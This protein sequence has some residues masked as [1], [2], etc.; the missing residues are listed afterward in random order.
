M[1][2][3]GRAYYDP[4]GRP[5]RME[6]IAL[7]ITPQKQSERALRESVQRFRN[8]AESM[9][10]LLWQ[11]NA[12]GTL[13]YA[14]QGWMSYFGRTTIALFE[15]GDV[16]HPDDLPRVYGSWQDMTRGEV[17]IDPFRLRRH[18][19]VYRWFGCRSV[20]V[21]DD[22]GALLHI[23]GISTDVDELK[24][25]E[26][27]LRLSQARL[28]AALG[29]AGMGTWVWNIDD[30][31]FT[32]D[33]SMLQL[34]GLEAQPES[35]EQVEALL[36]HPEDRAGLKEAVRRALEQETDFEAEYRI[37]GPDQKI[38]W[39][40]SKGQLQK[41][42]AGGPRRLIGASMDV[43]QHRRLEDELR[44]AQKMEAIGQLAGGVAHD[45]NNLLT[46]ILGQVSLARFTPGIP[47]RTL[48]SIDD[49]A[50]AAE[51]AASLTAQL[52]AFGRRQVMDA[53]DLVLDDMVLGVASM[54]ERMLGEQV[55]MT[56]E[57]SLERP[58]VHADSNML[59][60]VLLNLAINARDAMPGGG[61]LSVRVR[62]VQ[63]DERAAARAPDRTVRDYV[64]LSVSDTGSGIPTEILPH[65]FEPFFTTKELGKGTG[66]GLATA[67][68]IVRQHRGF[69]DVLS[70]PGSGTTFDIFLPRAVEQE[71]VE[72]K[73][74]PEPEPRG[75]GESILLVEDEERV[76]DVV[77]TILQEHDYGPIAVANSQQAFDACRDRGQEIRLLLTDVVMPDS[78]SG[79]E[80][81]A[82]L[83]AENPELRVILCSGYS[84]ANIVAEMATLRRA[85]FLQ[86][87][88]R[89]QELLKAVRRMLD[90]D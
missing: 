17:N 11:L 44:Q 9:P 60:Q 90:A 64:C 43:T 33:D 66:L 36:I 37:R 14:N 18:D 82:R 57:P 76:R 48:A 12:E 88:Y 49:I 85:L 89:P 6:G 29:A 63:L 80:L 16:V 10:H 78:L 55:S 3:K 2:A 69:I 7:D 4:G 86:K 81:A 31:Q 1:R 72:P 58:R 8:L 35:I 46:V 25:V 68:G 77:K 30:N 41:D 26:E 27:A 38:R 74:E 50:S 54:L 21:F 73:A 28:S 75:R 47:P 65:I 13:I 40:A 71:R 87:P 59:A 79:T 70:A 22:T 32:W 15:W 84:E 51:R 20:P 23:I 67:Y 5:L 53:R 19:G 24:R 83:Q 39:I 42:G 61:R 34:F 52:L 56:F 45:F 62:P